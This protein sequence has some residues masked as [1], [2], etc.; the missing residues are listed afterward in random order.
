[1]NFLPAPDRQRFV[2]KEMSS[3]RFDRRTSPINLILSVSIVRAV[4]WN[5]QL[6]L[7]WWR[8]LVSCHVSVTVNGL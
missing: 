6:R 7:L 5:H 2:A 1:M 4:E 3:A 8:R